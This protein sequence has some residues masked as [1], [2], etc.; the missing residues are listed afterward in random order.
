MTITEKVRK[1]LGRFFKKHELNEEEDIF[2]LGFVNSLFAM[3][4]VLFLEKEFDITVDTADLDLDNFK[5]INK[6]V[7]FVEKKTAA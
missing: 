4:L 7:E 5:T 2:A 3:Q 6:I 1:F